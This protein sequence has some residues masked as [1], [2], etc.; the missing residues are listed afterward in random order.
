MSYARDRQT[1]HEPISVFKSADDH[2]RGNLLLKQNNRGDIMGRICYFYCVVILYQKVKPNNHGDIMGRICYFY[3]VV[4]EQVRRVSPNVID[5][6]SLTL[7]R[8][9]RVEKGKKPRTYAPRPK[10]RNQ[11]FEWVNC[12][13]CACSPVLWLYRVQPSVTRHKS[14]EST[15]L[16]LLSHMALSSKRVG[17]EALFF[18][19][20]FYKRPM[21]QVFI[22]LDWEFMDPSGTREILVLDTRALKTTTKTTDVLVPWKAVTLFVYWTSRLLFIA[23]SSVSVPWRPL[24]YLSTEQVVR[25]HVCGSF[26]WCICAKVGRQVLFLVHRRIRKPV[27]TR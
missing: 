2:W 25:M 6:K 20:L 1:A 24:L 22:P 19:D 21:R 12:S 10:V 7:H 13:T 18:P 9:S 14:R 5:H 27:K 3:C 11:W 8:Y 17:L 26:F 23:L 4:I 15:L 16:M